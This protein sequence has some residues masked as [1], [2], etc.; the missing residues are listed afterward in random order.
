M[1]NV[2]SLVFLEQEVDGRATYICCLGSVNCL[3]FAFHLFHWDHYI[4]AGVQERHFWGIA[5]LLGAVHGVV[6]SLFRKYT[7]NGMS[8]D[9]A[10]KKTFECITGIVP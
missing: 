3:G 7:E 8:E 9:S 1:L 5:I 10:Y 4:G 6:E 2:Y